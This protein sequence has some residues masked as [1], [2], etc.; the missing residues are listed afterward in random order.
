MGEEG[1]KESRSGLFAVSQPFSFICHIL[2]LRSEPPVD[3][4]RISAI[5]LAWATHKIKYE[6]E[7]KKNREASDSH[8]C[9]SV[10]S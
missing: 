8:L 10:A 9:R 6:K 3:S 2:D 1:R 5:F 7:G 4:K